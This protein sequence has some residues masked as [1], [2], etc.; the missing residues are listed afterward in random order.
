MRFVI[1]VKQQPV[2]VQAEPVELHLVI[3]TGSCKHDFS[4]YE[5]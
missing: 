3:A 4:A 2:N 5:K 1:R